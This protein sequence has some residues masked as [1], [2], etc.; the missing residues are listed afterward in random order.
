[1]P[2]HRLPKKLLYGGLQVG[3]T[4]EDWTEEKIKRHT[5]GITKTLFY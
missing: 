4:I 3:K 5:E 2:Y 1:M